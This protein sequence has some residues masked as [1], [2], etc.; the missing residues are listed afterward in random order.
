MRL[1]NPPDEN[2]RKEAGGKKHYLSRY[3]VEQVEDSHSGN[4][5]TAQH[6]KREGAE[7]AEHKAAARYVPRRTPARHVARFGKVSRNNL[8]QRNGGSK[9]CHHQKNVERQRA[10][11]SHGRYS[12]HSHLEHV[13]QSYEHERRACVGLKPGHGEHG[14]EYHNACHYGH[15]HIH[16]SHGKS[17]FGDIGVALEIRGIRTHATHTKAERIESLRHGRHYYAGI[18]LGEIGRKE[19]LQ[20]FGRTRRCE[21]AHNEHHHEKEKERHENLRRAFYAALHA[22]YHNE[23]RGKEK[24]RQAKQRQPRVGDKTVE[25]VGK[26]GRV[27]LTRHDVK[28]VKQ[29]LESIVK[30]PSRH[31]GIISQNKECGKH[32]HFSQKPPAAAL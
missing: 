4:R 27:A 24:S 15:T 31:N 29:R 20:P 5:H 19:E 9:R 23:M 30:R 18:Y 12:A 3:I 2:R 11:I 17:S 16:Q 22:A 6:A 8:V 10:H 25:I 7:N 32:F 1:E 28:A 14:G 26:D 21:G 13:G